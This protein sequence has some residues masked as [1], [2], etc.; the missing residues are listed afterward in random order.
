MRTL[1]EAI[2]S[3]VDPLRLIDLDALDGFGRH[4][5]SKILAS[6]D[7]IGTVQFV[8]DK[9]IEALIAFLDTLTF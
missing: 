2:L 3:H 7:T 1:K 4:E 8:N 6:S 9:E 5:Y